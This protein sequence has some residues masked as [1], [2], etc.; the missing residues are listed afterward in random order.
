MKSTVLATCRYQCPHV[1]VNRFKP[2]ATNRPVPKATR[3]DP[4]P[5]HADGKGLEK[6]HFTNKIAG[7]NVSQASIRR[8][9]ADRGRKVDGERGFPRFA[10]DRPPSLPHRP[11]SAIFTRHRKR[12]LRKLLATILAAEKNNR[13]KPKLHDAAALRSAVHPVSLCI[14]RHSNWPSLA[15]F[16]DKHNAIRPD[17]VTRSTGGLSSNAASAGTCVKNKINARRSK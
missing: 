12:L 17:S 3:F 16:Y 5:I 1:Y 9:I 14:H 4:E 15:N 11:E 2:S 10:A 8:Q 7:R 13:P 6:R